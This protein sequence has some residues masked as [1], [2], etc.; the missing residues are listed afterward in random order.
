MCLEVWAVAG[1]TIHSKGLKP[2]KVGFQSVNTDDG[3]HLNYC[4]FS[5][6]LVHALL[7]N[8]MTKQATKRIQ[9][10][11]KVATKW[12]Q[13]GY[14]VATKWLQT[15]IKNRVNA[16]SS[17]TDKIFSFRWTEVPL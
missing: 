13:S 16:E 6:T 17:S 5:Q 14:K 11:D 3:K 4:G 10:D 2:K 12:L 7:F 1:Y 8:E 15:F 9:F